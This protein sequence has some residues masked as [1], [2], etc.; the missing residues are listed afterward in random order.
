LSGGNG[1]DMLS[2]DIGIDIL[3]GGAGQ[4]MFYYEK[5]ASMLRPGN[6]N[7]ITDF[8]QGSDWL[9]FYTPG[10]LCTLSARVRSRPRT[11]C[12]LPMR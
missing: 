4:D 5:F 7:I 6:R 12:G 9:Q 2:G 11:R 1:N 3:T 8:Q 10:D